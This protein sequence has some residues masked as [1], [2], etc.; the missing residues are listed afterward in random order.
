MMP[1]NV[2]GL[3]IGHYTAMV[4]KNTREVGCG[5]V[6][7]AVPDEL[8]AAV[9]RTFWCAATTRRAT[10]GASQQAIYQIIALQSK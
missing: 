8:A 6:A 5:F 9:E 10:L 7:G 4:W 3:G 2:P 1:G